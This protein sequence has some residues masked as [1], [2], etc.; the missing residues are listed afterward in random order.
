MKKIAVS[1][2]DINGVGIEIALKAHNEISKICKPVYCI[3][4]KLLAHAAKLLNVDIP[5]DFQTVKMDADFEIKPSTIDANSGRFSYESFIKAIG[6]C[7]SDKADAVVTMPIH[8]EAW[9]LAGLDYKGHTD[10]LRKHF[11]QDAIMMLGCEKM[12]VA[13]YTEHIPL[14]D[15][16]KSI[17]QDKLVSFFLDLDTS[18]PKAKI[19]VLGLNPH[20]GDNGVLG[21]EEREIE[22]AIKSVNDKLG[23]ERYVG[24]LVPD[25]AF[26]PDARK[27]FNYY[28]AM[29]HD[30]GLTPLKALYF[31]ESVNIS[32]N[33]PIVRTSVDHGTAFDIAYQG[34]AKTLSYINAVKS[35]ISLCNK[36]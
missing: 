33:L 12:F 27:N 17:K 36:E 30:Q 24:C 8:K 16:A 4:D 7:E 2:G 1:V 15:V 10:L 11:K 5:K 35:A 18:L 25:V 3:N 6:L 21:D 29:Y 22:A 13:L 9:S 20:A 34:K 31:D 26:T 14:K 19:A 28:V 32:L 23:F